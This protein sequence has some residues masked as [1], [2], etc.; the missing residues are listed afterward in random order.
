MDSDSGIRFYKRKRVGL[1][2]FGVGVIKDYDVLQRLH[3]NYRVSLM[4]GPYEFTIE[5][6]FDIKTNKGDK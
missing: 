6:T 5:K 1:F 3:T 4:L 2:M